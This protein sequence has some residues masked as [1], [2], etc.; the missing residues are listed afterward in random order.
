MVKT[1][2][3]KS[4][5]VVRRFELSSDDILKLL[6]LTNM[7]GVAT[8]QFCVP[9][10]GEWSNCEIDITEDHPIIVTVT[11]RTDEQLTD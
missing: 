4:T 11:N 5:V 1:S 7:T 2:G 6:K 8:V 10:G 3:S 9:G